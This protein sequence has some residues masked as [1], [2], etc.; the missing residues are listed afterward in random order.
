MPAEARFSVTICLHFPDRRR[1]DLDN[2]LK[3]LLDAVS[4]ALDVD[5]FARFAEAQIVAEQ[6]EAAQAAQEH[7]E[8]LMRASLGAP[9]PG[10]TVTFARLPASAV[11]DLVGTLQDG[12]PLR[13]L[14][15]ELGPE[16][17]KQVRQALIA[18]VATGQHPTVIARQVR[19]ALGGNLVRALTIARTEVLR[20][21]REA[22]RQVYQANAD[23][24][25]GWYWHAA[26][27][28]R[29]CLYC[30]SKH[31]SFHSSNE[32]LE[33]HPNC[34]CTMVPATKSWSELGFRDIPETRVQVE[35]GRHWFDRQPY[36]VKTAIMHPAAYE[37]YRTGWPWRELIRERHDPRWG[38]SGGPASLRDALGSVYERYQQEARD[39]ARARTEN[40]LWFA[41]RDEADR[42]RAVLEQLLGMPSRWGGEL[43]VFH[44]NPRLWG[45]K[46]WSCRIQLDGDFILKDQTRR[47]MVL[48]HELLHSISVL[49][50]DVSGYERLKGW[51]EGPVEQLTRVIVRDVGAKL[52]IKLAEQTVREMEQLNGY[53]DYI[54]VLEPLRTRLGREPL[55]FYHQMLQQSR[56]SRRDWVETQARRLRGRRRAELLEALRT[57]N[58]R[59]QQEP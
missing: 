45:L 37:A 52:G 2:A 27:G 43:I 34:R 57:A 14:L 7:A 29:T 56:K 21:Y 32:R 41:A 5:D 25:A 24:V 18:G 47:V 53:N 3:L 19:E 36:D 42:I 10:V 40:P 59:L 8:Q 58:E 12:S 28:K 31:G 50:D 17:S 46:Q 22:T 38:R 54:S 23:V 16:A 13:D 4:R 44:N 33:S 51:E 15:D 11:Q 30:V 49:D 48:V 1:R 26:L 55:E 39:V 35:P 20:S 6:H 9:P